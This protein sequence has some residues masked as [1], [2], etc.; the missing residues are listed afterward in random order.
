[1]STTKKRDTWKQATPILQLQATLGAFEGLHSNWQE[2]IGVPL[3]DERIT[4]F[5]E[6][7]KEL[8]PFLEQGSWE[9]TQDDTWIG[10]N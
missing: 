3:F 2:G 4:A 1:M 5:L 8:V 9:L 10:D 6:E 7:C